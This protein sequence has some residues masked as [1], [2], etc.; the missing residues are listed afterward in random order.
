MESWLVCVFFLQRLANDE[1][2]TRDVKEKNRNKR[3][4][5]GREWNLDLIFIC[6]WIC[7][8]HPFMFFY[9][10]FGV[11]RACVRCRSPFPLAN[12]CKFGTHS[13]SGFVML[14][15]FFFSN[16]SS[17]PSQKKQGKSGEKNLAYNKTHVMCTQMI[18]MILLRFF[19][20]VSVL[21]CGV[22]RCL[23]PFFAG[24]F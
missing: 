2:L 12:V 20:S 23:T 15:H 8:S 10:R 14:L 21:F 7:F 1:C 18:V 6:W 19:F 11:G 9:G 4:N 5:T 24:A 22:P 13:R 16:V 17:H 3:K